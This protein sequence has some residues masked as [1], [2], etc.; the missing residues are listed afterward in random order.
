MAFFRSLVRF[1]KK[2]TVMGII[3]QTQG[4]SKAT[5]PPM[6][7]AIKMNSHEVSVADIVVSPNALS[8]SMT[9]VH[10]CGV[11]VRPFNWSAVGVAIGSVG[12]GSVV[13]GALAGADSSG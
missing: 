3:G 1:K 5:K 4:V 7:P 11:S 12:V 9:G 2:L 10:N 13:A 8:L 6:N